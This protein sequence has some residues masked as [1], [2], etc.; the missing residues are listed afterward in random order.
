MTSGRFIP[1]RDDCLLPEESVYSVF[2]KV[3][4]FQAMPPAKYLAILQRRRHVTSIDLEPT[5]KWLSSLQDHEMMP[6]IQRQ[7]FP[8]S[9]K[10]LS[11]HELLET[12]ADWRSQTLRVCDQCLVNGVHLK[13]HQDIAIHLCPAHLT[14][15]REACRHCSG[16]LPLW[17][18]T[19][20]EAFCCSLCGKPLVDSRTFGMPRAENQRHAVRLAAKQVMASVLQVRRMLVP[21]ARSATAMPKYVSP[22]DMGVVRL[23]SVCTSVGAHP[24][25]R[26]LHWPRVKVTTDTILQTASATSRFG[27]EDLSVGRRGTLGELQMATS[28]VITW[29]LRKKGR[30]HTQCLD[31]PLRMFGADFGL[32]V[33]NPEDILDCC[34][35]AVGFWLWRLSN[36]RRFEHYLRKPAPPDETQADR[37]HALVRYKMMKSHLQYCLHVVQ[38]LHAD[39]RY[40]DKADKLRILRLVKASSMNDFRFEL[41]PSSRVSTRLVRFEMEWDW[42]DAPC[43]GYAGYARRIRRQSKNSLHTSA[44]LGEQPVEVQDCAPCDRLPHRL[45]FTPM[46]LEGFLRPRPTIREVSNE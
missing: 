15:L 45:P 44:V 40:L 19:R 28:C 31:A 3:A 30:S 24:A 29:F 41:S 22:L 21:Y 2:S 10:A 23:E 14:P 39:R 1:W 4:W 36:C 11:A 25:L 20:T 5:A 26:R 46:R 17:Y 6:K 12:P 33:R 35:V 43:E 7:C 32:D 27:R 42:M 8:S 37:D 18:G 9:I 34:P 13:L 16:Y 38:Q